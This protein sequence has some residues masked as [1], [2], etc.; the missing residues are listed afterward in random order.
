MQRA[1]GVRKILKKTDGDAADEFSKCCIGD[2]TQRCH[3]RTCESPEDVS[4]CTTQVLLAQVIGVSAV[5]VLGMY[6]LCSLENSWNTK[7]AGK[8]DKAHNGGTVC[9]NR[10]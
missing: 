5:V 4:L 8:P 9:Y 6:K 1:S 2:A 7:A 10:D 3:C